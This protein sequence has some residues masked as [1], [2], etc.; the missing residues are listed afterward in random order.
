M[1]VTLNMYSFTKTS[2]NHRLLIELYVLETFEFKIL[3]LSVYKPI[4][5]INLY[6]HYQV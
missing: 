3:Q 4:T 2:Q 6:R 5:I 1:I